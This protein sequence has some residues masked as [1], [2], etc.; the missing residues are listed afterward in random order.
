M[1]HRL[2]HVGGG[3]QYKAVARFQSERGSGK[4]VHESLKHA[5]HVSGGILRFYR[6]HVFGRYASLEEAAADLITT[7]H[8]RKT[9]GEIPFAT[10]SVIQPAAIL[11]CNAARDAPFRQIVRQRGAEQRDG[12]HSIEDRFGRL[13]QES[14][15]AHFW[16]RYIGGFR[17]EFHLFHEV[18]A[19]D[20]LPGKRE[21][22]ATLAKTEVVPELFRHVHTERGRALAPVRGDIP[23]LVAASSDRLMPQPCEEVRKGYLP[24]G[25]NFR[26]FHNLF[27]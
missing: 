20:K 26:P 18:A 3:V 25:V 22:V 27:S 24:H 2:F 13:R 8:V 6:R 16:N 23:Q 7:R 4:K 11:G 12:F 19:S 1:L 15:F 17:Y 21:D 14:R 9:D 5:A 10:H